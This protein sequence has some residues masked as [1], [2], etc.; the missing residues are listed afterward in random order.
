MQLSCLDFDK[1]ERKYMGTFSK[2]YSFQTG[3]LKE[4]E[5]AHSASKP[6]KKYGKWID[7]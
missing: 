4:K 5:K 2:M 1:A 6:M 3:K 7:V